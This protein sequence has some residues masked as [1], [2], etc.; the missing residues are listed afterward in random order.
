MNL[1]LERIQT[2]L[3]YIDSILS[4]YIGERKVHEDI[5]TFMQSLYEYF[6]YKEEKEDPALLANRLQ[7]VQD[8]Y[9][10]NIPLTVGQRDEVNR[11]ISI[12]KE[13]LTNTTQ[14]SVEE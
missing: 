5:V 6:G 13:E 10:P 1:P 2:L 11:A 12:I 14:E 4:K 9:I 7:I 8:S 3:S